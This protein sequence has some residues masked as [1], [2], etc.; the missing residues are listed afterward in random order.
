MAKAV[1]E[2]SI[3]PL[4]VG[5]SAFPMQTWLLKPY[6]NATLS[7]KQGYFNYR[8][9]RAR[10]VTEGAYG[11]LKGRCRVLLR[12]S[13]SNKENVRTVTLACMVLHNICID[14]GD[15]ISRKLDLTVDPSTQEKKD[16]EQ[17]RKLLLMT[18]CRS[19]RDCGLKRRA[20]KFECSQISDSSQGNNSH[21]GTELWDCRKLV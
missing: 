16:R 1:G 5:D 8:L 2:V 21:Q 13:E 6:T 18:E 4:I 9:S 12:K 17:I 20:E 10:M 19:S 15:S 14:H 3:P 7:P 11:Q